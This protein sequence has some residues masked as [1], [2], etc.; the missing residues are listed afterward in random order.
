MTEGTEGGQRRGVDSRG[1]LKSVLGFGN[2]WKVGKT[3][4]GACS[5]RSLRSR[6]LGGSRIGECRV[7]ERELVGKKHFGRMGIV[8]QG[9]LLLKI[10][11]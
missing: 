2:N 3:R 8:S 4:T 11:K 7:L 1:R 5:T 10:N 9:I 6:D